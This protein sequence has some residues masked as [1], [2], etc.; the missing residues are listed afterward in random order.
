MRKEILWAVI[1]GISFGLIIAFGA[2]RINSSVNKNTSSQT[3][4]PSPQSPISEFKITLDKPEQNDVVTQ[5]SVEVTGITKALA[6]IVVSGEK[7]DY[8]TQAGEDG[9]FSQSVDLIAGINQIKVTGL[10]TE[11]QNSTQK[12]VVVY[13]STFETQTGPTPNPTTAASSESAIRAKVEEKVSQAM[14]KPKAYIGTVTD[15][16]DST[17]QIKDTESQIQQISTTD[18]GITAVNI[19]GTNNKTIKISDIA[20]GDFIAA[21]GY[22]NTESVLKAQRILVTDPIEDSKISVSAG[23]VT[24]TSRVSI[25]LSDLKSGD[26]LDIKIDSK[27]DLESYV[28]G[29]ATSAKLSSIN[30]GDQIIYILDE[31]GTPSITRSVFVIQRASTSG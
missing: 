2:W 3:P 6:W 13:S 24:D 12:L 4:S 30:N 27:T 16:A 5:D 23:K 31:S 10:D 17:I 7:G 14:N 28:D 15:I 20:I 18:S 22:V 26:S 21:M 8:I 29:K 11:G 1:I 25:S 9:A 19:K